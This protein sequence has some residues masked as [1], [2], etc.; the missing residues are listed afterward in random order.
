MTGYLTRPLLSLLLLVFTSGSLLLAGATVTRFVAIPSSDR[1]YVRWSS[2]AESQMIRYELYRSGGAEGQQLLYTAQPKGSE[3]AYEYT[4]MDVT[5]LRGSGG[6]SGGTTSS[7]AASQ[8][9]YTLKIIAADG[10]TEVVATTQFQTSTT[11]RT[12]GSIKALFR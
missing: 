4:D 1:I 10:T 3:Q 5:L 11:R 12:W 9:T 2:G 8:Y 7:P 6:S